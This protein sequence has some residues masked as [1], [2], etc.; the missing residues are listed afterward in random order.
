M[1]GAPYMT[2]IEHAVFHCLF[3]VAIWL[4]SQLLAHRRTGSA[5]AETDRLWRVCRF[6]ISPVTAG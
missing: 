4:A 3:G 1:L 5:T 2:A 6:G